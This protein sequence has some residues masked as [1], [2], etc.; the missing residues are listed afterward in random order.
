MNNKKLDPSS[1]Q[2]GTNVVTPDGTYTKATLVAF[3]HQKYAVNPN[4]I[5]TINC[6]NKCNAQ[7]FFCYNRLTFMRTDDYCSDCAPELDRAIQFAQKAGISVAALSGGEPTLCPE[8]LVRLIKKLK[9]AGMP[10]VRLHTNGLRLLQTYQINGE[11]KPL[12]RFL[13]ECGLDEI[14]ISVA[15]YRPEHNHSIMQIDNLPVVQT[16]LPYFVESKLRVRL[17]CYLCP[18]GIYSAAEVQ[19][20]IAFAN[21]HGVYNV[22]FRKAPSCRSHDLEYFKKIRETLLANNWS[23]GDRH[24]KTDA[25]I[26]ILHQGN[27]R[28]TLSCVDEEVDQDAKIRRLIY[29]PDRVLY[30]SWIN[31]ASYLFPDDAPKIVASLQ[32]PQA[33]EGYYPGKVWNPQVPKYIYQ[34]QGQTIDLHVHSM[35]SDGLKTPSQ[36]LQ[37]AA[38][39]GIKKL[40]F[41]EHNCLHD[42]PDDLAAVARYWKIQIPML[43]VEFSTVYCRNGV[44]QMKFH[45]LVYGKQQEQFQFLNDIFNPNTPRNLHLRQQYKQAVEKKMINKSWDEIFA[46][47]DEFLLT[48]KKMFVR[49]PL[50]N[51]ISECCG[52]T[53]EEA[54]TRY[55]PKMPDEERYRQYLDTSEMIALAHQNGCV[56]VLA[57]PGWIRPYSAQQQLD[58]EDLWLAITDLAW[59]GLDGVEISHRLNSFSMREKLFRLSVGLGLIPTGGSDFHGKPRCAWGINGTTEENLTRLMELIH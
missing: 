25:I 13:I 41:T 18:Q 6:T 53:P 11:T 40:V 35:V 39:A 59:Q 56:A 1:Y 57:H 3:Q 36:V 43:G 4:A 28:V 48:R 23:M 17:S 27:N 9:A 30:T 32:T 2:D 51:A 7:C 26:E 15:D 38:A 12:W 14:S 50:A 58:E 52:I 44:P 20:Y 34:D 37:S 55:L 24:E 33:S 10:I 29:M 21:A 5:F 54:K 45:L 16:V 46:I 22:I 49:T 8:K 31:P 47:Q 42:F 19:D